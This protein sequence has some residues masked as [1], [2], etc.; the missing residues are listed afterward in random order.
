[1]RRMSSLFS[2]LSLRNATARN[3]LWLPPMCM[4]SVYAED[5]RAT[6]WH[7]QHYAARSSG[8]FGT[9]VVEAT[10]VSPEGRLSPRD[11]GLWDGGQVADFARI[12]EA[13]H[14]GGALAGV[15]LGHG[16]RKSE[17]NPA[18]EGPD[19]RRGGKPEWDLLAPSAVAFPGMPTPEALDEAGIDRLVDAFA[20][21]ASRAVE[22][23]VDVVELHGA[24]GY[25]IH[26][27]LSP[28][29]NTRTDSYGGSEE[30]RRRFLLR[31]VDGVKRAVGDRVL[32][33]RL[34]ATDWLDG[35]LTSEA[36]CRLSSVLVEHGVDVLH[37][38]SGA[39]LPADI[40]L[41]PGYQLPFAAD[42]KRAVAG[43]EAKVVGVGMVTSAEQAEQ[44][45]V[46]GQ[47][48]AVAVGRLALTD[49]YAP[50]RWAARLGVDD[51][52]MPVQYRRGVWG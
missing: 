32:C 13:I 37:I 16:G 8:G 2:P 24:H 34:S 12:V 23:G 31:I 48:D 36:T 20:A 29:S 17:V 43:S 11:L 18:S 19:S 22:A 50:L 4:Y 25:L 35:G 52:P 47:C 5:G 45:L 30:N 15:Q 42:V 10:A 27:F 3:R 7:V 44:A 28:L 40:P 6:D 49:P 26:E 46:T 51:S 21:A 38:S 39:L 1:M 14:A 33:V 41:G 9:I